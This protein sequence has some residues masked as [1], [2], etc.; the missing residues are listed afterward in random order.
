MH[1]HPGAGNPL[2][3]LGVVGCPGP[4]GERNEQVKPGGD[5]LHARLGQMLAQGPE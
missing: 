4:L 3:E 2:G 5:A 1:E